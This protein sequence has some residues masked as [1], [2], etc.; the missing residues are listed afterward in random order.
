M[1]RQEEWTAGDARPDAPLTWAT[2]DRLL[3]DTPTAEALR[4]LGEIGRGL[5]SRTAE[6]PDTERE[7]LGVLAEYR[8]AVYGFAA[9]T[10]V[11]E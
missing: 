5:L 2:V 7:L 8:Y 4:L 11:C 1:G 3:R 10:E 9:L 6:L